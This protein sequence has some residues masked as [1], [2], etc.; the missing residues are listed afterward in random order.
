MRHSHIKVQ[1]ITS[2]CIR[3][4]KMRWEVHHPKPRTRDRVVI[5]LHNP[6]QIGLQ[7]QPLPHPG[8]KGRLHLPKRRRRRRNRVLKHRPSL[9]C[10]QLRIRLG[11]PSYPPHSPTPFRL[12]Q[13]IRRTRAAG[14]TISLVPPIPG[15]PLLPF[16]RTGLTPGLRLAVAVSGGADSVALL[17]TLHAANHLP[18]EALGLGLSVIHIHH[19]IR[20]DAAD[21]DQQF[22]QELCKALN[23]PLTL[24]AVDTPARAGHEGETLEEAARHLRYAVFTEL[25]GS[26]EADA[27]ATA[28]TADDQAETVL[29]KL[30][31]G[32]WTEGLAGIFPV[33]EVATPTGRAGRILRPLLATDRTTIEG[34][35]QILG[36]PWRIDE[37]NAD[38][39]HTRNR[40]RHQ[41]LPALR[42][43]N[44]SLNGTLGSLAEI[45]RDEE[46][47]WQRE[48]DRI[49]PQLVVPGRPVRGGGRSNTTA[50]GAATLSIELDRLRALHPAL[51]RRV[52]RATARRLGARLSFDEVARLLA[53]AGLAAPVPTIPSRPGSSLRLSN[54]LEAERSVRELH[55]SR[56]S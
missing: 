26:G 24:R 22:V 6:P 25:I 41:L 39:A 4:Q 10:D 21:A 1:Q 2:A 38:P 32:A 54:G 20:G 47:F 51:R 46:T 23:L 18:R 29:I 27:I 28:H 16:D 13:A 9:P 12:P 36:Q 30:L 3:L 48:L 17:R 34:Y 56:Q 44:P 52:L 8:H 11:R 45:A 14:R 15:P 37:T 55:L 42:A 40:V 33:V 31:R 50:P 7:P 35:L 43:F 5:L 19:G 53:L 49:L